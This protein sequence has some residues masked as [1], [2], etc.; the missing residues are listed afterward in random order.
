MSASS[1][2]TVSVSGFRNKKMPISIVI[3]FII[4]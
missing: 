3:P 2:L 4:E 1:D